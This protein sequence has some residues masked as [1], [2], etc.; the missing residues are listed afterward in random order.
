MD[1]EARGHPE[2]AR[3]LV[4]AYLERTG[5]YGAVPLLDF[6]KHY[7][8]FVRAKVAALRYAQTAPTDT[9]RLRLLEEFGS[10][11]TLAGTYIQPTPA[12]VVLTCGVTGSGKTR[13]AG[14]LVD[15][16]PRAVRIRSDVERKRL[17]GLA[18]NERS[19]SALGT[20][21]Y[22]PEAT[23]RTYEKLRQLSLPVGEAGYVAIVDATFID[24]EERGAFRRLALE[25]GWPFL[26]LVVTAPDEVLRERVAMRLVEAHDASEAD[27]RVLEDQLAHQQP[28]DPEEMSAALFLDTSLP[29]D[30]KY[31][32][33]EV[34]ERLVSAK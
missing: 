21:L 20:R 5:D 13:L 34:H 14:A 18:A 17:F 2:M 24:R 23:I 9:A 25:R 26:I 6:Y 31:L 3:H 16:L 8:A 15:N 1:L 28:L 4:N 29:W 11:L 30:G 10:Y 12:G 22:T 19:D 27:L 32:A 7:R 33:T